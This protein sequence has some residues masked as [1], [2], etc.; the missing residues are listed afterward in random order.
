MK[1]LLGCRLYVV[2][3]IL[4]HLELLVGVVQFVGPTQF[5][6]GNWVGIELDEPLGK[7]DGSVSDTRLVFLFIVDLRCRYGS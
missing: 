4:Y 3:T 2:I 1:F 6:K 7:N 5:A